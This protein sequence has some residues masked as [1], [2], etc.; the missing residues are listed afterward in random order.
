MTRTGGPDEH[1]ER[2]RLHRVEE[3]LGGAAPWQLTHHE[4]PAFEHSTQLEVRIGGGGRRL[5]RFERQA[6]WESRTACYSVNSSPDEYISG[7]SWLVPP[8][9]STL[10]LRSTVNV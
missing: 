4:A 6:G 10:P 8:T 5:P 2:L 9:T 7:S 3:V 1:S